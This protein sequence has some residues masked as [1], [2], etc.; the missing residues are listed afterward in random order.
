MDKQ[1]MEI[2]ETTKEEEDKEET[3]TSTSNTE[4]D[5]ID[6]L[7]R[8]KFKNMNIKEGERTSLLEL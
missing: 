1:Q 6:A 2:N 7:L 4:E 3:E 8:T 5:E